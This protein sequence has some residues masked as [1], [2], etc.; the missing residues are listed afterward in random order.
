MSEREVR[1]PARDADAEPDP[2]GQEMATILGLSLTLA[3]ISYSI[4]MYAF[5]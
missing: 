3:L 1:A 2:F 5:L 4:L